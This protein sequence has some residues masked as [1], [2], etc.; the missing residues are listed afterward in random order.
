M[1][2]TLLVFTSQNIFHVALNKTYYFAYGYRMR[3]NG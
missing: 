1:L 2:M 3:S